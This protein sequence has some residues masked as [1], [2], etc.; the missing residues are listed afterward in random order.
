MEKV[1][2]E[3]CRRVGLPFPPPKGVKYA[4]DDATWTQEE[5][6]DFKIWLRA[7]LNKRYKHMTK[8]SLDRQ[9][10]WI[11]FGYGWKIKND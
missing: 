3:L 7:Y 4:V 8:R 6:D 11:I 5:E 10:S 1:S 2:E 9:V